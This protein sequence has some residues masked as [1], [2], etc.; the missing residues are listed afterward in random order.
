MS[1]GGRLGDNALHAPHPSAVCPVSRGGGGCGPARSAV[2]ASGGDPPRWARCTAQT[3]VCR[4]C[5]PMPFNCDATVTCQS[6]SVGV[7]GEPAFPR[8]VIFF[9]SIENVCL[10][11]FFNT[12]A[13]NDCSEPPQRADSKNPIFIFCRILGPCHLRGPGVSLGRILG[14]PFGGVGASLRAVSTL[15]PP[16]VESPPTQVPTD[17][18]V[19]RLWH[20]IPSRWHCCGVSHVASVATVESLDPVSGSLGQG[21]IRR[22]EASAF[23]S[24]GR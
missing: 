14:G 16:E 2:D 15:P 3:L 6:L 9:L 4:A 24:S 8:I 17:I 10:F 20:P 5:P 18:L 11:F 21:C 19:Q 22:E 12:M 23:S 7:C 1:N 13:N